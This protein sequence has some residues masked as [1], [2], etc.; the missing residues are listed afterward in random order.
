M[1]IGFREEGDED[2]PPKAIP[3]SPD[4]K[5]SGRPGADAP[6][7]RGH[8]E[9]GMGRPRLTVP[10]QDIRRVDERASGVGSRKCDGFVG[11]KIAPQFS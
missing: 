10:A 4:A 5:Q 9:V 8:K 7:E 3:R 2:N 1:A 6:P 11:A